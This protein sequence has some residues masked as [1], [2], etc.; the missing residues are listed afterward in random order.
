MPVQI[1]R[2]SLQDAVSIAALSGQLGYASAV[3]AMEKRL[4]IVLVHPEHRVWVAREKREVVGWIHAC[5]TFRVESDP[6]VEI[7]G[8]VVAGQHQKKGIG[9]M[10]V[11]EAKAW[12]LDERVS[13]VRVR[14]NVLRLEAHTFYHQIGFAHKKDQKIFDCAL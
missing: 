10:L 6:F 8:L 9:R 13:A 11:R 7:A 12:A 4:R 2:A 14:C 3:V 5:K 1:Q